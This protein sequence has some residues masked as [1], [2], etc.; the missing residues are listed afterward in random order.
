MM[1]EKK[2]QVVKRIDPLEEIRKKFE[3]SRK[4]KRGR[5]VRK[6]SASYIISLGRYKLYRCDK[7]EYVL[8]TAEF[9]KFD[10]KKCEYCGKLMNRIFAPTFKKYY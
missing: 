7:C 1:M 9:I 5:G 3:E 4:K 2:S 10:K 8:C 6:Q